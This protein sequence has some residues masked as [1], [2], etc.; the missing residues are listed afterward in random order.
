MADVKTLEIYPAIL[1]YINVVRQHYEIDRVFLFGSYVTGSQSNDSDIDLAIVSSS[2]SD[3]RFN[4]NVIL[5]KLTWGIDT[6][7]E[8]IGFTPEEFQVRFLAQ[9]IRTKGL[10]VPF[11]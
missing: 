10:E 2:F 7:I 3:N 5:G 1:R 11:N 4:D 9:E 8:P 6:R